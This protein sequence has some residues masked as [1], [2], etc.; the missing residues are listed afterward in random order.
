MVDIFTPAEAILKGVDVELKQLDMRTPRFV[1]PLFPELNGFARGTM[2][3]D[4]LWYDAF[5]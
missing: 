3:L 1:N 5:F 2:R 4:S